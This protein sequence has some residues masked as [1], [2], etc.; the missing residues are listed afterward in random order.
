MF[1]EKNEQGDY[2]GGLAEKLSQKDEEINKHIVHQ[3]ERYQALFDKVESLLP[4]AT[5]TGLAT[6]YSKQKD[7]YK[8][9]V[10]IWV[11]VFMSSLILLCSTSLLS[12]EGFESLRFKGLESFSF[13]IFNFEQLFAKM[14]I[15]LPLIWLA[16]FSSKQ[17][18]QN[19]RLEQEYVHKEVL[20]RTYQ[21]YKKEFESQDQEQT[22]SS[23]E[24]LS[25]LHQVLIAAIEKNQVK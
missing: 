6:A 1:G 15:I 9:P 23:K 20:T 10:Y 2:S 21:G 4:A 14:P 25:N 16:T 7:S 22:N 24:M 8:Y 5:S 13:K 11:T 12:F 3:I 18:R 19:K 17:Y